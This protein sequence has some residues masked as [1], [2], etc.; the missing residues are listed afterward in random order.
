MKPGRKFPRRRVVWLVELDSNN[1]PSSD[2][3]NA[4]RTLGDALKSILKHPY[5]HPQYRIVKFVRQ[6]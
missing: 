5:P 6:P 3:P 4:Y 2:F 1:L